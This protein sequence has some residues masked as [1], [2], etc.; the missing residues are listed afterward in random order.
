MNDQQKNLLQNN[1]KAKGMVTDATA[2][3][4]LYN[5]MQ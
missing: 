1:F 4:N 3:L 5:Q 2:T